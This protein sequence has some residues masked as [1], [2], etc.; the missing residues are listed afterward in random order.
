MYNNIY[1]AN[2]AYNPMAMLEQ[3]LR[4]QLGQIEQMARQYAAPQQLAAP[5]IEQRLAAVEQALQNQQNQQGQGASQ[6][7]QAI[8]AAIE[9]N[10]TPDDL[11]YLAG[12]I[13]RLPDFFNGSDG[14][15]I[16]RM[17]VDGLKKSGESGGTATTT[18]TAAPEP[19][20]TAG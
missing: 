17:V 5:S 11:Q 20:K 1:G 14:R 16:L 13:Q 6:P 2:P 8:S 4:E 18:T 15:D 12:N 9:K 10:M 3:N 7:M 19:G